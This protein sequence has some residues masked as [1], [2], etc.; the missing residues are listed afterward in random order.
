LFPQKPPTPAI[1]AGRQCGRKKRESDLTKTHFERQLE[2][3]F[4]A[5]SN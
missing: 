4:A 5:P 1:F 2:E 3:G